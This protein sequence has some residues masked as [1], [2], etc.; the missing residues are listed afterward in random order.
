M[1]IGQDG[2][3]VSAAGAGVQIPSGAL[4]QPVTIAVTSMSPDAVATTGT[5]TVDDRAG[6][7][8]LASDPFAFTPHGTRF[9]KPVRLQLPYRGTADVVIRLDDEHDTSWEPV[10]GATFA[11]GKATVEV[12]GF[13]VY[14]VARLVAPGNIGG[15][16][17]APNPDPGSGSRGEF[18]INVP[19][20][21][22]RGY[23]SS[24]VVIDAG[25]IFWTRDKD[26]KLSISAA[27]L[28]GP[29]PAQAKL[30]LEAP[31]AAQ[32]GWSNPPLLPTTG[33]LIFPAIGVID[34]GEGLVESRGWAV[35]PRTQRTRG[36][37]RRTFSSSSRPPST[38]SSRLSSAAA[39]VARCTTFV[40]PRPWR[41]SSCSS[42]AA[43]S[44]SVKPESASARQKRFP[45][46][47]KW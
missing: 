28:T 11:D 44:R 4:T 2:G 26:G 29:L 8:L 14:A 35:M 9:A 30:L 31:F 17:G 3:A 47:A 23:G 32:S 21:G 18:V 33:H 45:G 5:L 24:R 13:S 20:S 42:S 1:V 7:V 15:S 34:V 39:A 37:K 22:T 10:A 19:D 46:R 38:S 36:A 25:K 43:S 16:G 12:D 40:T 41:N 6:V 27:E